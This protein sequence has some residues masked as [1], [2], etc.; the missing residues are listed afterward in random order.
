MKR[1][2]IGVAILLTVIFIICVLVYGTNGIRGCSKEKG[3]SEVKSL[4]VNVEKVVDPDFKQV[5]S[6]IELL[7]LELN[8]LS[9][10]GHI[11]GKKLYVPGKYYVIVDRDHVIKVF[12]MGGRFVS[13]SEKCVGKGPS[14][15]L[16]LQDISYNDEEDTFA[17]LDP[18]GF[19]TIYTSSFKFV[20]KNKISLQTTDRPRNLFILDGRLCILSDSS[21]RGRYYVYDY[22]TDQLVREIEYPGLIYP[23][24]SVQVPFYYMEDHL[25]FTPPEIND[26]VFEIDRKSYTPIPLFHLDA[27]RRSLT[28]DDVKGIKFGT[29]EGSLFIMKECKK[30][31]PVSRFFN[32]DYIV[33]TYINNNNFYFNLCNISSG[34]NVTVSYQYGNFPVF[35][36]FFA[37]D[38]DNTLITILYPYELENYMDSSLVTDK[39]LFHTMS[40]EDN[41]CIVKY[42]LN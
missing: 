31:S 26:Y 11:Y 4:S 15:Y 41:P 29:E 14:E 38:K 20:S 1:R 10:V 27:G 28:T 16:I 8:D 9:M 12:D 40:E 34:K 42:K 33:S 3:F 25:Y 6:S 39:G 13:S 23:L 37:L 32:M 30:Y 5:F 24:S 7:P 2:F 22:S 19:I 35:P 18:F 36:N 17:V 21:E